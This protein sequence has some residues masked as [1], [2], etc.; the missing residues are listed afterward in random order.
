MDLRS[1]SAFWILK[2]GLQA[3]YP[4]LD[5][6][7]HTDIAIIGGGITGA[8]LAY[9]FQQRGIACTLLDKREIGWGS[10]AAS[11]AMLQ[12][13]ID[14]ELHALIDRI[15]KPKAEQAYHLGVEA[16]D[17]LEALS[18]K[19]GADCAF[20]RAPSLY[21]CREESQYAQLKKEYEARKAA[22][23]QV[24]WLEGAALNQQYG[25]HAEAGIRSQEAAMLDAF[26][27]THALLQEVQQ[28]DGHIFDRTE[29]TDFHQTASGWQLTTD[30]GPK[31]YCKKI[32]FAAGYESSQH[33][34]EKV[35][36]LKS[37]YALATEPLD[38]QACIGG[39]YLLWEASRPYFYMRTTTDS[40][41]LLGGGDVPFKN[42]ELRDKL[43]REKAAGLLDTFKT[44][45]PDSPGIEAAFCWTG[46]FGETEDGLAYIGE[47]PEWQDAYFAMGY[48]G[49]GITYSYQAAKI[50]ADCYQQKPNPNSELYRF[51]R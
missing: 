32:A 36:S 38:L 41:L 1:G 12:Y 11:T 26:K 43:I 30:R 27:L 18:Q 35:V 24:E 47:S 40:R 19:V 42:A 37:T 20:R 7:L 15:G 29:V 2:N 14:E 49:N 50:L 39:E 46:T 44:L 10:T 22:G 23:F 33:L 5:R 4:P 28:K 25:L 3:A 51:G 48:G 9:E 34:K 13:E 6:D 31:V 45:Y 17:G 21:I 16:I 8:L